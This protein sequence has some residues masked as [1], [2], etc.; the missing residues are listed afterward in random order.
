MVGKPLMKYESKIKL[1][2]NYKGHEL[3]VP[4]TSLIYV[5]F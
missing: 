1:I 4:T 3:Q 2:H 5:Y